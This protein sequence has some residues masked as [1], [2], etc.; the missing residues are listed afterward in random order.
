MRL[1]YQ[2]A[3]LLLKS[4][5]WSRRDIAQLDRHY[6]E[7]GWS[8]YRSAILEGRDLTA[9]QEEEGKSVFNPKLIAV[10]TR[11]EEQQEQIELS[12]W[13]EKQVLNYEARRGLE[14][15]RKRSL[16]NKFKQEEDHKA[17]TRYTELQTIFQ[18][19]REKKQARRADNKQTGHTHWENMQA[20]TQTQHTQNTTTNT[21]STSSAPSTTKSSSSS[22]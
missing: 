2:A 15:R 5:V 10:P 1:D 14:V 20:Q 17:V 16:N 7:L 6:H 11:S 22:A 13:E 8:R 12:A 18:S 9:L 3:L 19:K 21:P 4:G